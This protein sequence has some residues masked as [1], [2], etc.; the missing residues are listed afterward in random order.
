MDIVLRIFLI[1]GVLIFTC[2][3]FLFLRKKTLN[4]NYTLLWLLF[5]LVL[6]ITAVFPGIITK[7]S[8]VLNI[9]TPSNTIFAL[10]LFLILLILLS[11]T[12][13]VSKQHREIKA[14]TQELA[15]LKKE[16]SDK[17]EELKNDK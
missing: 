17:L 10:T 16:T 3:L 2:I 9:R 12:S 13:I 11:I 5:S 8:S 7:V 6:L 15:L 1:V 4:L 14:L